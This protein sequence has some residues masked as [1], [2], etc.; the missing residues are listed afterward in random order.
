MKGP[1]LLFFIHGL[2]TTERRNCGRLMCGT[3]SMTAQRGPLSE[4]AES[5]RKQANMYGFAPL[6]TTM[7]NHSIARLTETCRRI[8]T[9]VLAT[10]VSQLLHPHVLG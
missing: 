7:D 1:L 8:P 5:K 10:V 9:D 3:T 4:V 6:P 2:G